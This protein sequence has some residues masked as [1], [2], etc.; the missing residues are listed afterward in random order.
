MTT[1]AP[2]TASSIE[3]VALTPNL[4]ASGNMSVAGAH[5][6]TAAPNASSSNKFERSTRL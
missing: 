6:V 1:S 3:V 5:T 2:S 4:A